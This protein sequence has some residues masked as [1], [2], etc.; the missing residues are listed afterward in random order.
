M[1]QDEWNIGHLI[2]LSK[3]GDLSL[4]KN[5][6]GIVLLEI[7]YKIIAIILHSRLQRI[8]E[9]LDHEPQCGFRPDRG[10]MDAILTIKTTITKCSKNGL[11]SWELFL[12]LVKAF[13]HVPRELLWMILTNFWCCK[14]ASRFAESIT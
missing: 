12:V 14:E 6:R 4:P 9:S 7:A 8:E 2:I 11:E 1:L 10:C 13:D 5:Y 3:K